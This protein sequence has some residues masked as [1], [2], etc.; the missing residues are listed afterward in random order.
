MKQKIKCT[1]SYFR[2]YSIKGNKN[3][4]FLLPNE[5]LSEWR[6]NETI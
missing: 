3:E 2:G 4:T 1:S 6:H 5:Y